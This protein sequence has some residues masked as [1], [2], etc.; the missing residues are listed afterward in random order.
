MQR[1]WLL[2]FFALAA[3]VAI[4][5]GSVGDSAAIIEPF[6]IVSY[7]T[8]TGVGYGAKVVLRNQF[9]QRE[10]FDLTLFNSSKGERWYRLVFSVPDFELRQ[11]TVY[12]VALDLVLD[13]DKWIKNSFFG[14]GR[15]SQFE[16]RE[17]YTKEPLE[18]SVTL[19][20]GFSESFIGQ[21]GARYKAIR[22]FSFQEDSRLVA[23][24]PDLNHLRVSYVALFTTLRHDSRDSYINPSHGLVVQGE[25]ERA[26]YMLGANVAFYRF[27]LWTH[28]YA[29]AFM[30]KSVVALRAGFQ[31]IQGENLPT[32][33]LMS[34]GGNRDLRGSPQDR[35]LDKVVAVINSEFRFPLYWRFGAIAGVDAGNTW[36]SPSKA[37]LGGW[38]INPTAGLRFFMETFVV[39]FDIGFGTEATGFYLN[40]GQLF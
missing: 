23:L 38:V 28:F 12:P 29:P 34:L 16:D 3:Q 17:Y 9:R 11:G 36:S 32:Q 25:V 33:V 20:R 4:A 39:R 27:A 2:I 37:S 1:F 7:D 26:P 8:D 18:I 14:V 31:S 35:Y 24:E 6:P 30:G 5:Q 19:S 10:S 21:L 22:N 40:F 13:Y 15:T